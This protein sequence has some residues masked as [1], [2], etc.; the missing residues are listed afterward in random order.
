MRVWA[1]LLLAGGQLG[2]SAWGGDP[3]ARHGAMRA[4]HTSCPALPVTGMP[5]G[6]DA[7]ANAMLPPAVRSSRATN[8]FHVIKVSSDVWVWVC[9]ADGTSSSSLPQLSSALPINPL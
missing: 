7:R 8:L 5:C 1:P 6:V 2:C 4:H 3:Q 9:E